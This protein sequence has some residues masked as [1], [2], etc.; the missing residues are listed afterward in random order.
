MNFGPDDDQGTW[1]AKHDVLAV[2]GAKRTR[3][4]L[5]IGAARTPEGRRAL[6]P[7]AVV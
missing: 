4:Y 6:I 7:A 3:R 2:T 1:S 5:P